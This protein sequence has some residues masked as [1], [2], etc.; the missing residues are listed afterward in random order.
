MVTAAAVEGSSRGW[1]GPIAIVVAGSIFYLVTLVV[2]RYRKIDDS[3]PAR[4]PPREVKDHTL[5]HDSPDTDDTDADTTPWYGK[6]IN[7]NGKKM[8]V[9]RHII[10]TGSSPKPDLDIITDDDSETLE[11]YIAR[12]DEAGM[13][14]SE[15]VRNAV[16]S[17][18]IS[19]AT[20]KRRIRDIR[21][22]RESV[23]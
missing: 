22:R 2:E 9:A 1:G 8:R 19:E 20:A 23:A 7:V 4:T 21:D 14:Y 10:R 3:S 13:A 15:I 16:D 12:V 5:Y 6:I 11:E 18:G 17:Y